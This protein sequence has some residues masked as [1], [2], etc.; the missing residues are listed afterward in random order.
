[1]CV[2]ICVSAGAGRV[3]WR[4]LTYADVCGARVSAG[5]GSDVDE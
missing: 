1:M 3:C 2:C 5:N 4:M